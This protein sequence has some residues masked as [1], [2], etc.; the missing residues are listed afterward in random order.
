MKRNKK[1]CWR[2]KQK[3]AE[4]CSGGKTLGCEVTFTLAS[5][6]AGVGG[7]N[8]ATSLVKRMTACSAEEAQL[9]AKNKHWSGL[10]EEYDDASFGTSSCT[11]RE[12]KTEEKKNN[13]IVGS[14]LKVGVFEVEVNIRGI[15]LGRLNNVDDTESLLCPICWAPLYWAV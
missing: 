4:L 11:Y 15:L 3:A 5:V 12:E 1:C 7:N 8:T 2:K 14:Q 10:I 6:E 9:K 13:K